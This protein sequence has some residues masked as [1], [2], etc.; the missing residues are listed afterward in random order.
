MI[1]YMMRDTKNRKLII[2]EK[3]EFD[4]ITIKVLHVDDEEDFLELTKIYLEKISNQKLHVEYI[5]SPEEVLEHLKTHNY[6]V[7]ISDYQMPTIDGLEL[8][9]QLRNQDNDIPFIIFTGKGREEVAIRALNLGADYYIK[10][11]TDSKSQYTELVHLINRVVKEKTLEKELYRSQERF[12]AFFDYSGMGIAFKNLQREILQV[13]KTLQDMLNYEEEE[14]LN[15]SISEISHHEDIQKDKELFN[16]L[17]EG[18]SDKYSI[19]KRCIKKNGEIIWFKTTVTLVPDSTGQKTLIINI[20]EDITEKIEKNLEIKRFNRVRKVIIES[21]N[22]LFQANDLI[23]FLNEIC[24]III[25][26]GG[27][28]LAWIGLA[29]NEE[30]KI[31][32]PIA[33]VGFDAGYLDTVK[34]TWD[35]TVYG[36]GPTGTAIRTGEIVIN[37]ETATEPTYR[38]WRTDALK[39]GYASSI[40]LPLTSKEKIIGALNIYSKEKNV[41][42]KE[43]VD[44]LRN[45]SNCISYGI[46]KL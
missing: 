7:L 11:G 39:R 40:A 29:E 12:K 37:R 38:P 10:K 14:L 45:L 35:N 44:L 28:H 31:V 41:F 34:I 22:A 23:V 13:N 25:T 21:N 42:N 19:I 5:S 27:Y 26:I 15:L 33:Q 24:K 32:H 30:T 43:E 20:F 16:E 36:Q 1:I 17:I 4:S 18:K 9:E 46:M 2:E 6:D 3:K 8:I